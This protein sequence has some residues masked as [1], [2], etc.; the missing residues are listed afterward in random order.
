MVRLANRVS[1]LV[2]REQSWI[3]RIAL[4]MSRALGSVDPDLHEVAFLIRIGQ[5]IYV[6]AFEN[7]IVKT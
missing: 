3:D 2:D 5:N 6:W 1:G 7:C 4:R